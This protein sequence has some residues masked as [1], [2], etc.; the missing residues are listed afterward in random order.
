MME[1][2]F[3]PVPTNPDE[4]VTRVLCYLRAFVYGTYST[5]LYLANALLPYA[6]SEGMSR[7]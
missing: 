3:V 4:A 5:F 1:F 2:R 6:K 7:S